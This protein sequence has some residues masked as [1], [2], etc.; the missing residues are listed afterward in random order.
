MSKKFTIDT[1]KDLKIKIRELEDDITSIYQVNKFT[2]AGK[3]NLVSEDCDI[4][5]FDSGL[6]NLMIKALIENET[7]FEAGKLLFESIRL[8][9]LQASDIEYERGRI[10]T[11]LLH[12]E[13][14]ETA[15]AFP[16]LATA[17]QLGPCGRHDGQG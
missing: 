3:L 10:P 2:P 4:E 7:E 12:C 11:Y 16:F 8:T 5:D 6:E 1:I 9:P 17:L 14:Q 13:S 15:P